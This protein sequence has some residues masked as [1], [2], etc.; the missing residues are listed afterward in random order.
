MKMAI[1]ILRLTI[2][3]NGEL[4]EWLSRYQPLTLVPR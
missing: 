3:C 2:A 4:D 1:N